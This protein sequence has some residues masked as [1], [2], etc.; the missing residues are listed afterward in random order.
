M[1]ESKL[2][3][4]ANMQICLLLCLLAIGSNFFLPIN[5]IGQSTILIGST[6]AFL[7]MLILPTSFVLVVIVCVF[8][9]LIA[10]E[11]LWTFSLLFLV[12]AFFIYVLIQR[13]LFLLIS[14]MLYWIVL[15][16]PSL[17]LINYF[18][19]ND[20]AGVNAIVTLH[21]ALAGV[22]NAAIAATLFAFIPANWLQTKT[23]KQHKL[24]SNIF[25]VNAST[26]VVPILIVSFTFIAQHAQ[27]RELNKREQLHS[28]SLLI[29]EITSSFLSRHQ[30]IVEQISMAASYVSSTEEINQL[31]VAA[32]IKDDTFFNITTINKEGDTLYFAPEKYNALVARLPPHLRT[33]KDRAYFQDAKNS[34]RTSVSNAML[35]RGAVEAPMIAVASPIIRQHQFEGIILGAINLLSLQS[36]AQDISAIAGRATVVITDHQANIIYST[37]SGNIKPLDGFSYAK[38]ESVV[39]DSL[40]LMSYQNTTYLYDTISTH[41][42]W[43]I[44]VLEDTHDFI[45]SIRNQLIWL[46]V[47]LILV[48]A[49][50]LY[51][52]Y[53][54][55]NLITA[56]LEALLASEEAYSTDAIDENYVSLEISDMAKRLKRTSYLMKNFE[57]RL[58]LQVEEKTEKLEQLNLQLAAQARE[59]GLTG[60]YNRGGFTE[61]A[62]NAIKT[63][64]RHNHPFSIAILDLDK[65][66]DINDT[67]GHL[68]GD[69]CLIAFSKLMQNCCKRETD[70]I[71]RFGGEEF[72][73]FMSGTNAQSQQHIINTIHHQ[74]RFIEINDESSLTKITFTVSV[75]VCTVLGKVDLSLNELLNIADEELY[76][77]KRSG[78]DR[79]SARTIA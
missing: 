42:R 28:K 64:F 25:A 24:S 32:Q 51:F 16:V 66:K 19:A 67:Y 38:E 45:Y 15:G 56:P 59:D 55:S 30:L 23:S 13:N 41:Y 14:A 78:R 6:F 5:I 8:A 73:I 46:S 68:V 74:T 47:G 18:N 77:S 21:I 1:A 12:E 20:V 11:Q 3:T 70:I 10:S 69:Q 53:K 2:S 27:E 61:L 26:L 39:I 65:F 76:K 40:K 35:S 57:N 4:I 36:F 17:I 52:A 34:R 37:L 9:S 58:K 79:L 43:K 62:I 49:I 54:M 72:V 44:F 71:G 31:M 7:A 48:F 33:V 60:L 50:F 75:G 22:L 63:S 29:G